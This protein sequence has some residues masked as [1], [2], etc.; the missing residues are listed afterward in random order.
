L[1]PPQEKRNPTYEG[2]Y[3]SAYPIYMKEKK[4]FVAKEG[5]VFCDYVDTNDLRMLPK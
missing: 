3:K 2:R 5:W 1:S 4:K